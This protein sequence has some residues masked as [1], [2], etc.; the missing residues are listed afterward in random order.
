MLTIAGR[1]QAVYLCNAKIKI[2][3][4]NPS[5]YEKDFIICTHPNHRHHYF[6]F[7]RRKQKRPGMPGGSEGGALNR[8][9]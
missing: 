7:M 2:L 5:Q 1:S 3:Q 8:I 6:N 4:L 9:E